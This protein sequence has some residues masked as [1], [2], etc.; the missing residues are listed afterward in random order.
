MALAFKR[1]TKATARL[2]L[3]L[4]GPAGA[5]K[6]Y[7]A[8][9]IATALGGRVALI[10]T[11]HGSASKYADAFAFDALELERFEPKTYVDAIRAAEAAGYDVLVIDSLSHAWAGVGGILDQLDAR[12]SGGSNFNAWRTLTPQHNALV[13][14]LLACRCHLVVTLRAKTA[15]E[16]DKDDRG[17]TTVRKLGLAPVQRDGLEYEFDV[18]MDLDAAHV[19]SVSKTRCSALD[20]RLFRNPGADVAGILRAWLT[21]GTTSAVRT[22][23]DPGGAPTAFDFLRDDLASAETPAALRRVWFERRDAV[24]D[25]DDAGHDEWIRAARAL[26]LERAKALGFVRTAKEL[27]ALLAPPPDGDGPRG[28]GAPRPAASDDVEAAA[29]RAAIAGEADGA[30]AQLLAA[31]KALRDCDSSVHVVRHFAAH[32]PEL[33]ASARAPYH[34]AAV[35]HLTSRYPRACPTAAVATA[36]LDGAVHARRGREAA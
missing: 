1:A 35:E 21:D 18:V 15:Y 19:A 22:E 26:M 25:L 23:R 13:E 33:P 20:G 17:K 16:V 3:G 24:A 7:S 6:T 4:I 12:S 14:A 29:E 36:L 10:D 28:G 27:Q 2:R 8:L 31:V 11:E 5:G 32:A 34:A 30:T 9:A